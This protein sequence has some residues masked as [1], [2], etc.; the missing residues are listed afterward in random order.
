MCIKKCARSMYAVTYATAPF[1][2]VSQ[3]PNVKSAGPTAFPEGNAC[4][5]RH[6]IA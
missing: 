4:L 6:R 3:A 2:L 1:W 5:Q